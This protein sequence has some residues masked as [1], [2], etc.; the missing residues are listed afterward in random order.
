MRPSHILFSLLLVSLTVISSQAMELGPAAIAGNGCYGATQIIET[1]DGRLILPIRVRVNKK[2]DAAFDRKTC[3]VRVPVSLAANEKLEVLDVSYPL[4]VVAYQGSEVKSALN[5]SIVGQRTSDL[6]LTV[7]AI[8]QNISMTE[9]LQTEPS[10]VLAESKC[11]V[12]TMLTG[13]LSVLV[14][15]QARAFVS[16]GSSQVALKVVACGN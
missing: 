9:L 11:G 8:D 1:G 6:A 5:V 16:T 13:N 7:T 2:A 14:T 12:D 10:K 3:N 15:G 4:R